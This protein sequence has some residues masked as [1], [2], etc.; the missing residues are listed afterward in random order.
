MREIRIQPRAQ[1]DIESAYIYRAVE[2]K[3]PRAALALVN[4]FYDAFDL[5]AD[6]PEM[7]MHFEDDALE[8]EYRRKLVKNHWIY[9]TFD[10]EKLTVWRVFHA[11]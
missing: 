9:Y 2:L 7:G 10:A 4:A 5:L 8:L 6:F 1:L 11:R 3:E